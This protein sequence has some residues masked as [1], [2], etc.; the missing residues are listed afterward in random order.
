MK[1][2]FKLLLFLCA[3][4]VGIYATTPAWL[5]YV[6]Y[7]QLPPGWQLEKLDTGY[8]D[9]SGIDINLMSV[10]GDVQFGNIS[11]DA[12]D[13]HFTYRELKTEVG[14]LAVNVYMRASEDRSADSLT[15]NDLSLPVTNLT[16][17]LPVLSVSSLMLTLHPFAESPVF[18]PVTLQLHDLKLVPDTGRGFHLGSGLG[19]EK[20][21]DKIGRVDVEVSTDTLTAEVRFPDT[22]DQGT[23]L[24]ARLEQKNHKLNTST[25]IHIALDTELADQQW[26]DSIVVLSTGD[27][28]SHVSGK[29]EARA[30]FA[31]KDQQRIEQ[32][33]LSSQELRAKVAGLSVGINAELVATRE[34]EKVTVR[35]PESAEI[36][37]QDRSG[38]L[39][40]LLKGLLPGFQQDAGGLVQPDGNAFT[41]IH[42][43]SQVIIETETVPTIGFDGDIK[44]E[45]LT[46]D[47]MMKLQAD[48]L[49]LG[50]MGFSGLDAITAEGLL[51][52]D[53]QEN[54][55]FTY[56][57]DDLEL[58]A[59]KLSL[60]GGGYLRLSHQRVEFGQAGELEARLANLKAKLSGDD[61]AEAT[62]L[63]SEVLTIAVEFSSQGGALLSTGNATLLDSH[64]SPQ[65]ISANRVDVSWQEFDPFTMTGNLETRTEGLSSQFEAE[66]WSGFELDL[67][68][69]MPGNATIR[70]SGMLLFDAG[71][72]LP[73]EFTGNSK[74]QRWYITLLPATVMPD[75]LDGLLTA[76][77][78]E[79]PASVTLVDGTI[80]LRGKILVDEET[81]AE[82]TIEGREMD[83]A[84][85]ESSVG[86]VNFRFDTNYG[87]TLSAKGPVSVKSAL[88]AGGIDVLD[89]GA[90]L[91]LDHAGAYG[92][93]NLHAQLFDG[94][95]NLDQLQFLNGRIQDTRAEL[96]HIDLKQLLSFVDIDG[97]DGSGL[98]EI[99]LPL[100]SDQA[101]VYIKNG[102]FSSSAPGH[103]A[104]TKEGI[105]GSNIGLQALENF[106]YQ[107]LSG[108]FDYQSDGTYQID[109]H[110]E[111]NNP[112]LYAGHPIVFNLGIS[113]VLPELFESL[114][115]TGD[116]EES[117]LNQVKSR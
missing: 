94:H 9:L 83:A 45:Y 32:L 36:R 77:H 93:K 66:T 4:C 22:R 57:A 87:N 89:I 74:T 19:L 90:N 47:T 30:D 78:V 58:K 25:R 85:L 27:L 68:Y 111:G 7:A 65:S 18:G 8:P 23:W 98:L 52:F 106:H 16:G 42:S 33:S 11:L 107:V 51:A 110:I 117:I 63:E 31:G 46:P 37:L 14:L 115:M 108:T 60:S 114:F 50:V 91:N 86:G 76:L 10:K 44:F 88:L 113:G 73:V 2:R 104:Y 13:I 79:I 24:S 17:R 75:Q 20:Y 6:L 54:K 92:L 3:L 82:L 71:P 40:E 81:T 102:T 59:D 61:P 112:D 97:L 1:F 48:D 96:S 103:L 109:V 84:M 21:P 43:D 34:N 53:W 26:L 95:L 64:V 35:L 29:L 15:L 101:G 99:S 116:F 39:D 56:A 67:E 28:I 80:D 72:Q 41:E 12:S 5:R 62:T 100:G 49:N 38:R 105:A 69:S 70:G 55:P